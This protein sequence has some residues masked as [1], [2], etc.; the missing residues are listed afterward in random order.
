MTSTVREFVLLSPLVGRYLLNGR[1]VLI[2]FKIPYWH[3][4]SLLSS[5]YKKD[6]SFLRFL[7]LHSLPSNPTPFDFLTKQ[8]PFCLFLPQCRHVGRSQHHAANATSSPRLFGLQVTLCPVIPYVDHQSCLSLSWNQYSIRWPQRRI[9]STSPVTNAGTH[10]SP[11]LKFLQKPSV[12][13]SL[14]LHINA[15]FCCLNGD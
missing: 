10:P 15:W 13:S 6:P 1:S 7:S 3:K 11:D 9:I 14:I 2:R 4:K 8:P 12:V 5:L